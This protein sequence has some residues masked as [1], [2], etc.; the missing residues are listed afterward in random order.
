[1]RSRVWFAGAL[2]ALLSACAQLPPGAMVPTAQGTRIEVPQTPGPSLTPVAFTQIPGWQTDRLSDALPAFLIG[3]AKLN[4]SPGMLLGGTGLAASLGGTGGSWAQ[5]CATANTVLP[6]D[7]AAARTFFETQ[8]QAYVLSTDGS[9]QGLFTGYYEPELRGSPVRTAQFQV[10]LYRR[11]ADLAGHRPYYTRSQIERGALANRHLEMLWVDNPIDAFFL[12]IQ[13]AGRVELPDGRTVRVSFDGQNGR[14]YVAIGRVLVDRGEM[15]LPQVSLQSIRAW[16]DQHPAQAR[17]LMDQ[18]P[19]Y[20]FFK[21]LRS[22]GPEQ[23]PPGALGVQLTPWRSAAV[24]KSFV[25][26]G[27]PLF[28]DTKD[29]LDG[30]TPFQHLLMA[31]DLGGAI[32]GTVRADIFFGWGPD[33]TERAGR[34]RQN[35][36]AYLLLPKAPAP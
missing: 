27:A 17:E 3:C 28:L 2:M 26:L 35:G 22:T 1:M 12:E 4:A 9:A 30:T 7:D 21:E 31:Q 29:A 25:P 18:N 11:P 20:V 16:L 24:D 6:Q 23:G 8:F 36:F 15:T 5:A 32:K 14:P 33:P 10:P 13:G 34:M 19:S